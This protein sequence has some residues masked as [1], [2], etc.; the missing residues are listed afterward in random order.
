MARAAWLSQTLRGPV[1]VSARLRRSPSTSDHWSF[2]I[3]PFL[4]VGIFQGGRRALVTEQAADGA[5][6]LLAEQRH[7]GI[8]VSGV[9]QA[10]I[11][12]PG[13]LPHAV[14]EVIQPQPGSTPTGDREDESGRLGQTVKD[15]ARRFAQPDCA[16]AGLAIRQMEP[17]LPV[18][19]PLKGQD[20]RLAAPGEQ[21][22]A[23]GGHVHGASGLVPAQHCGE[24]AVL[25]G[26]QEALGPPL[27]VAADAGAGVAV[28]RAVSGRGAG[29]LTVCTYDSFDNEATIN[30]ERRLPVRQG[31]VER[32]G[33]GGWDKP[34]RQYPVEH[35]RD[36]A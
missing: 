17:P 9:V 21:Q 29:E 31:L 26:G 10:D 2:R 22:Q 20:L 28:F 13:L 7:A 36:T 4:Q 3:S 19:G 11:L 23:H 18:E 16:R 6:A 33:E 30:R 27:P 5:H 15:A 8:R 25:L 35:D 12:Q 1:L 14:P 24:A 34:Y 32:R